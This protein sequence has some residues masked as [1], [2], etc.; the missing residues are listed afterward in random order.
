MKD[1]RKAVFLSAE[2]FIQIDKRAKSTGFSS[3]DEYI[4]FILEEVLKNEDDEEKVSFSKEEEE[5]IKKR[6]KGLGYL[7]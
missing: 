5:E 3:V 4:T 6:L 1:E 7:D 2:L